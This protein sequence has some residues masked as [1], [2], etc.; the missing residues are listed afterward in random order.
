MSTEEELIRLYAKQLKIPFI[1][2][3]LSQ[4]RE[5]ISEMAAFVIAA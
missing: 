5:M 3:L 2:P 1:K 4:D